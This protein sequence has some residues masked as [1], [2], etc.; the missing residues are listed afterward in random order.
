MRLI[1]AILKEYDLI[2][3]QEVS[4]VREQSDPDCPR[5]QNACPGDPDCGSIRMALEKYLNQENGLDYQFVFSP[6]VRDERYLFIYN[7]AKVA[8]EFSTLVVDPQDT[9]PI[10]DD[11]QANL[12][13]MTRQPFKGKF[14]AGKF[15]FILLTAHTSPKNNLAELQALEQGVLQALRQAVPQVIRDTEHALTA[16]ALEAAQRLV[17]GLPVSAEMVEAAVRE[18]L[19]QAE[20]SAELHLYLHPEDVEL[21]RRADSALLRSADAER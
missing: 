17:A 14:V 1:A 4:N 15:D 11:R 13:M 18:A 16:L 7:P 3:V 19:A 12:G 2:A 6:Q 9:E 8:M 5:N 10:C 21:L 20:A